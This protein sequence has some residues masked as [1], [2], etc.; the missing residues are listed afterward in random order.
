[1]GKRWQVTANDQL[2]TAY[3]CPGEL[4]PITESIHYARLADGYHRCRDCQFRSQNDLLSARQIEWLDKTWKNRSLQLTFHD[5][6]V[7]GVFL[8][9]LT[10]SSG[11]NL[12]IAMATWATKDSVAAQVVLASDGSDTASEY[13]TALAEGLQ[14][15]GCHV[16]ELEPTTGP[17]LVH[18]IGKSGASGGIFVGSSDTEPRALE[19]RF[20]AVSGQPLSRGTALDELEQLYQRQPNG[21]AATACG[22]SRLLVRNEYLAT[23]GDLLHGLR[24]LRAVL[25]TPSPTVRDYL[26]RLTRNSA[27]KIL[28]ATAIGAEGSVDRGARLSHSV[29]VEEAHLGVWIDGDGGR[30]ELVD[31]RGSAIAPQ[32]LFASLCRYMQSENA[33]AN[34]L[35]LEADNSRAIR[36]ADCWQ[37]LAD[38]AAVL[39]AT[40]EGDFW[41]AGGNRAPDGLAT[42]ALVLRILSQQDW[43]VSKALRGV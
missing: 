30:I 43:P 40:A 36:R 41:Y 29:L 9:Q 4:L 2:E 17:G 38:S 22:A 27:C 28:P 31:E 25:D 24:P 37:A 11:Y 23:Y 39:A 6:G 5:E 19:I 18:A 35:W 20:F 15:Q 3:C 42:L 1:M 7:G 21:A 13:E 8:N 16:V 33:D 32:E 34:G 10:L 26:A 12:G 14:H